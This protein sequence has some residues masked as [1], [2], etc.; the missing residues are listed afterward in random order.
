MDI[1]PPPIQVTQRG[2]E[3]TEV[4]TSQRTLGDIQS[5]FADQE[6]LNSLDLDQKAYEVACY[7]PVGQGKEGGLFYGFTTLYPGKVGKE[8]FMTKG[9]FHQKIDTGEFYWGVSG[10]GALLFMDLNRKVWAEEMKPGSL[11]YI[12]GRV[13]HRTI[14]TGD[15]PLIFGACWPSDAG[16]NYE[17]IQQ[18][19]FAARIKEVDGAPKIVIP[20]N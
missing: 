16:H 7:F 9:H 11:H 1:I 15:E 5:I 17:T 10:K 14:N 12:P 20:E 13:A 19:G 4:S 2:L 6:A 8:Y 18:Q 3:G